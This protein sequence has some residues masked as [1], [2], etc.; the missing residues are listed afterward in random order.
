[1][2]P[3]A[4][5]RRKPEGAMAPSEGGKVIKKA[6]KLLLEGTKIIYYVLEFI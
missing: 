4:D 5:L 1:M 2:R 6:H 3:V